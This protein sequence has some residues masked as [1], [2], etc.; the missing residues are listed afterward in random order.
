[1]TSSHESK[2]T[3]KD[4]WIDEPVISSPRRWI[5]SLAEKE[6]GKFLV[7]GCGIVY[8]KVFES[9]Q[10]TAVGIDISRV[11]LEKVA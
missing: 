8:L 6:E 11:A 10:K 4:N 5:S 1:M 2:F 7:V 9:V 3:R